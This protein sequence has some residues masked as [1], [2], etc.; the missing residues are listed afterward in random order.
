LIIETFKYILCFIENIKL[1]VSS[2]KSKWAIKI[3]LPLILLFTFLFS[4]SAL[5]DCSDMVFWYSYD[6]A[7]Y[8]NGNVTDSSNAS[9]HGNNGAI[10]SI[11][12][13][14]ESMY[15]NRNYVDLGVADNIA[16]GVAFSHEFWIKPSNLI[17]GRM[18]NI[19]DGS[20]FPRISYAVYGGD[21]DFTA[22]DN[23]N[24]KA[25]FN[26]PIQLNKWSYIV[27]T[28]D[29][30]N[31]WRLYINGTNV[32]NDT[33]A[34]GAFSGFDNDWTIGGNSALFDSS[35]YNG[36]YDNAGFWKGRELTPS[37][38]LDHYNNGVGKNYSTICAVENC[39][40]L[41]FWYNFDSSDFVGDLL[42]D[43]TGNVSAN[44]TGRG[45]QGVTGI[46][47]QAMDYNGVYN[48]VV[49]P[50]NGTSIADGVPFSMEAWFNSDD[51]A[52]GYILHNQ[53]SGS[54][55][56]RTGIYFLSDQLGFTYRDNANTG[57]FVESA[58]SPNKWYHIVG[59]FDGTNSWKLYVNGSL[60]NSQTVATG[61][62]SGFDRLF[63]SGGNGKTFYTDAFDGTVDN[64]IMY[65]G[66]ELNSTEVANHFNNGSGRSY[67]DVCGGVPPA[68]SLPV[69]TIFSPAN[70]TQSNNLPEPSFKFVDD[71]NATVSCSLYVDDVL[72]QT[73]LAS[74]D[75]VTNFTL[76]SFP[77]GS[78]NWEIKCDDVENAEQES[79]K[80][81]YYYDPDEPFIQSSS[82]SP[83]NT[84]QFSGYTMTVSGNVTNINLTN[85]TISVYYPNSSLYVRKTNTSFTDPTFFG[86]T[87]IFNTTLEPNGN[88]TMDIYADD[89]IPNVN[90][91]AIMF[92][93][94]NCVPSFVCSGYASCNTSDLAK[95]NETTDSNA[96]GLP[97]TGNYSEFGDQA[98]NYC[99]YNLVE[100]TRG[101]CQLN[102]TQLVLY[103]DTNFNTCCNVTGIGSDCAFGAFSFGTVSETCSLY[104]TSEDVGLALIDLLTIL[105]L[106]FGVFLP[107][108][109]LYW[110]FVRGYYISKKK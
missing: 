106:T 14:D 27:V 64:L 109:T 36:F 77:T 9:N 65:I 79:G 49:T 92:E 41:W 83:F 59:T 17:N 69:I 35:M 87:W 8:N 91:M 62:F 55:R 7:D 46:V 22:V 95:C 32:V 78:H 61:S 105:L 52:G 6:D 99:S 5:E 84:T 85:V 43:E 42:I 100:L 68:P 19:Q 67:G 24:A 74:N 102:D 63:I 38:I 103:N 82:P 28:F 75:T 50:V 60:A 21:F 93:V 40:T 89:T 57:G 98:C 101:A 80:Y 48:N 70:Q 51:S 53:E 30:N 76:T 34:T 15:M 94:A 3:S 47:G 25:E 12:I 13:I 20:V 10:N 2:K 58:G 39:S 54:N 71:D 108:A 56:P 1:K 96:C 26:Y 88:W 90:T 18:L 11:G 72:N 97:Y 66:K 81:V 73:T 37:D 104:Y 31:L 45:V 23:A 29:G 44:N 107:V 16:N 4:V 33:V 86:Y 110:L